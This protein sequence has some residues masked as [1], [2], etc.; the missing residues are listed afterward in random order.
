MTSMLLVEPPSN[1]F[2]NDTASQLNDR[3]NEPT[4]DSSN[5]H[6]PSD[7]QHHVDRKRFNA[8]QQ[9]RL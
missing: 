6:Q 2:K 5:N 7:L 8:R 9:L 3:E 1:V 4:S